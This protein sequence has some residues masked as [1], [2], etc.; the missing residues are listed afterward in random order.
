MGDLLKEIYYHLVK[1]FRQ[2]H[3]Q[4]TADVLLFLKLHPVAVSVLDERRWGTSPGA[5]DVPEAMT[6][7]LGSVQWSV[8]EILP[9]ERKWRNTSATK[10]FGVLYN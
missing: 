1:F 5:D 3:R 7:L 6:D 8:T 10:I 9:S 2:N 4:T